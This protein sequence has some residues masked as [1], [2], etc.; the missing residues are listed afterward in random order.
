MR[1]IPYSCNQQLENWLVM[2]MNT[3]QCSLRFLIKRPVEK[4]LVEIIVFATSTGWC[5]NPNR[6]PDLIIGTG[7]LS[8]R[9]NSRRQNRVSSLGDPRISRWGPKVEETVAEYPW[10]SGLRCDRAD[11]ADQRNE[12]M[13]RSHFC[14]VSKW[15]RTSLVAVLKECT[16]RNVYTTQDTEENSKQNRM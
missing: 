3:S 14:N 10:I 9:R 6:H 16:G 2:L 1:N 13:N 7:N 12:S 15:T 4:G 5:T 11:G 8:P